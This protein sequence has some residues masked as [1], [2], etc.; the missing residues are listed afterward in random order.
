MKQPDWYAKWR[1][2]AVHELVEKNESLK[3]RYG[4]SGH[5]RYDYDV[6]AGTIIFSDKG[7]TIVT[8]EIQIVGTTSEKNGNWLWAWANDWWPKSAVS[9]AEAARQFGIENGIEELSTEYLYDDSIMNLGWEMTAV[10]AR[11]VDAIGAYRPPTDNG[12]IF[13]V[14]KKIGF[15][16]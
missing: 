11:V 3:Q 14:Y 16:H 4:L 10:T 12:H 2:D 1:H 9:F 6:D 7:T 13:F 8:A 15:A 5:E